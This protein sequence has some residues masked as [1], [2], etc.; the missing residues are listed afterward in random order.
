MTD[1]LDFDCFDCSKADIYVNPRLSE[2]ELFHLTSSIYEIKLIIILG[3]LHITWRKID[4]IK[5]LHGE[6]IGH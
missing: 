3:S 2:W 5:D 6:L 1:R 4:L